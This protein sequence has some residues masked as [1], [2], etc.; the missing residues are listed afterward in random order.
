MWEP[1]PILFTLGPLIIYSHGFFFASGALTV[2]ILLVRQAVRHGLPG[3]QAVELTFWVFLAGLAGSRL[4]Y[5]LLYPDQFPT[6][7]SLFSY[8]DGGLISYGGLVAGLAMLTWRLRA[9]D[10]PD[11]DRWL[12]MVAVAVPFG[13]AIGR[14]GN[15]WAADTVGLPS[16]VWNLTYG[17]VPISLLE[18]LWAVLI[19]LTAA[20]LRMRVPRSRSGTNAGLLLLH[21]VLLAYLPGR[22]I[23][24]L[25]R[26]EPK[27]V[28]S[29]GASSLS[30][31][32]LAVAV[33]ISYYRLNRISHTAEACL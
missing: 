8:W 12:G 15:Y 27:I 9:M 22:M 3:S 21:L 26:E 11:R 16:T 6:L 33:G 10:A 25:W 31:A 32:V 2:L 1:R 5:V 24:D 17:R 4:G 13:W 30:A 23:I 7:R 20:Y 18:G 19:G 29:W 28:S 14:L